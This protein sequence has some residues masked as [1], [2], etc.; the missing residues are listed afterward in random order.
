MMQLYMQSSLLT[1]GYT[2]GLHLYTLQLAVMS[3]TVIAV[4][5]ARL[6]SGHTFALMR[7]RVGNDVN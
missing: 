5:A 2:E 4:Y 3:I 7:C 6:T 1:L